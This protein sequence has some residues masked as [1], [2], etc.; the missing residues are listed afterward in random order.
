[1]RGMVTNSVSSPDASFCQNRGGRRRGTKEK[2]GGFGEVRTNCP[3]SNEQ[4]IGKDMFNQVTLK[5]TDELS[6]RAIFLSTV[7][8]TYRMRPVS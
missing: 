6:S 2:G 8:Q 3:S 7:L 4:K 1:M 5:E